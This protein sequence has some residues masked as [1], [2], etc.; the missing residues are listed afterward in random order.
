MAT[1]LV[2]SRFA[3][4]ARRWVRIAPIAVALVALFAL[5]A[6]FRQ[7]YVGACDWYGYYA[8]SLLLREGRVTMPMELDVSRY[9]A[10]V[11][12]SYEAD[13][14]R[15][16][17]RYPPGYPLLLALAGVLGAEFFVT[18]LCAALSVLVLYLILI[19]R[20][21]RL[22]AVL[23]CTV[24]AFCPIVV[25]GAGSV[26]SDVPA[27]LMLMTTY[28]LVDRERP[29]LAG[30]VFALAVATRP[31]NALFGLL[32]LPL[33]GGW[34]SFLR[35][36][37][38][39]AIGGAVY[40]LYNLEVFGAP[41]RMGYK[42]TF[43][44]FRLEHFPRNFPLSARHLLTV[45][46]AGTLVPAIVGLIR[47]RRRG[48]FFLAWF[49]LFWAVYSFWWVKPDPWWYLRFLLPGLPA[50]FV[51]A[52]DGWE[53]VRGWLDQRGRGWR[54]GVRVTYGIGALVLVAFSVRFGMEQR[55][56]TRT[57]AKLYHD[58]AM[59]ASERL[60]GGALI[61]AFNQTGSLR[62]YGGFETFMIPH[63]SSLKLVDDAVETGR[64]V[65]LLLESSLRENRMMKR[66]LD[67]FEVDAG[68]DLEGW[69]D[70]RAVQ[71]LG[72]KRTP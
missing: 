28:Y 3:A 66:L 71:V 22:V 23:A 30:I 5:Y 41:W 13:G 16:V 20:V 45:L 10:A 18:P 49:L 47:R 57:K 59:S 39:A 54:F 32:L 33:L 14:G 52:A 46:T 31:T 15:A 2:G 50:L 6:T 25:W 67:E 37:A 65:Y 62:L 11:P 12:L 21:S 72:R 38:T 63:P 27:A 60:P 42:G 19:R 9:P 26:M 1:R 61:G 8:Q 24:W 70:T 29:A 64:P 36:A 56:F 51:L 35:F 58:V 53:E 7:R 44:G 4:S 43:A 68:T 48:V 34:R 69:P 55:L 17:P 40:G